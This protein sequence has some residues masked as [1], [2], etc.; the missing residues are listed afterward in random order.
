[1]SE[2]ER[3]ANERRREEAGGA[4]S[5]ADWEW[6]LNWDAVTPDER[7]LVGSCPR[8]PEDVERLAAE[9][10]P[11][12]VLCLQ[13]EDCHRALQIDG[14]AIARRGA[15]LGLKM[16]RVPI[17]DFD[18]GDQGLM[19]PEAVR[20]LASLLESG[21]RVYVHCTA[22][23]NRASLVTVGWLT[24]VEG[25]HLEAAVEQVQSRR[26]Q[27][28]PYLDSWHAAKNMLLEPHGARLTALAEAQYEAR[29]ASGEEGDPASD[30]R[31]AERQLLQELFRRKVA[32][33][34]SVAN[35][36]AAV[37]PALG[38]EERAALEERAE[39]A[40]IRAAGLGEELEAA[41]EKA[42]RL[43][44]TEFELR[45][46][47]LQLGSIKTA[48]NQVY[49]TIGPEGGGQANGAARVNGQNGRQNGHMNGVTAHNGLNSASA[50]PPPGV[51]GNGH[52][53]GHTNGNG[54]GNGVH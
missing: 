43:D 5:S 3:E 50:A 21:H 7:V 1:M 32:C 17:R 27:A 14:A 25:L 23:I 24:F 18:H 11:T 26:Q 36:F 52:T 31:R 41:R 35:A 2:E 19:L 37:G 51:H 22:G 47:K 40:E 39:L 53:N 30:W 20:V 54:N 42:A 48:F 8:T 12:A 4:G 9:A 45:R 38:A 13:C 10:G 34:L 28:H 49:A 16:V 33:D 29:C 6:T 46:L 15:E 44:K